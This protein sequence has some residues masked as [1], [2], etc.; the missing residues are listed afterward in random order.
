MLRGLEPIRKPGPKKVEPFDPAAL[1]KGLAL[2]KH[3][4]E[5]SAGS[6][7]LYYFFRNQISRRDWDEL[8]RQARERVHQEAE[9]AMEHIDWL[10]P[11]MVWSMDDTLVIREPEKRYLHQVRDAASRYIFTPMTGEFALGEDVAANLRKLIWKYGPP[12]FQKRDNGSNLNNEA[13]NG[14]LDDHWIIPL[15]SPPHYPQYNG[16]V[17]RS[18]LE[19]K[20]MIVNIEPSVLQ[21]WAEIR[22]HDR[23]HR[24]RRILGRRTPCEVFFGGKSALRIYD[25]RR[26]K[27]VYDEIVETALRIAEKLDEDV[28]L[29]RTAA[30]RV[31]VENWLRRNGAISVSSGGRV[32]PDLQRSWSHK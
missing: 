21:P 13:V 22:A 25:R 29:T 31:S 6:G 4:R 30:W 12:L 18:Q 16:G 27:G 19:I 17:E 2:L 9:D 1:E 7:R 28:D 8:V 26:R 24:V 20:E 32:S 14:V 23:N 15:N 3:G 5:R 11:G 10:I